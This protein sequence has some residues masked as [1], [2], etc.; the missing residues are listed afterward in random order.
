MLVNARRY[1]SANGTET[2]Y[3]ANGRVV[4]QK[5]TFDQGKQL[6]TWFEHDA[7]GNIIHTEDSEGSKIWHTITDGKLRFTYIKDADGKV[8]RH[9]FNDDGALV[10]SSPVRVRG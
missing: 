4:Y 3:D 5:I 2:G 6:E 9:T 10:S 1:E 7:D 8:T